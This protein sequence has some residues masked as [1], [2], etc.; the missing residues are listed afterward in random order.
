MMDRAQL[1]QLYS[2]FTDVRVETASWTM[3]SMTKL[4]EL[5]IVD[6]AKPA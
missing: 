3:Q 4:I 5:W 2:V 6:A 1:D